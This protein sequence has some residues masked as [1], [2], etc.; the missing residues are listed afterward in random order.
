MNKLIH[1]SERMPAV[2]SFVQ[3]A[4]QGSFVAAARLQGISSAAVS[5]NIAGLE[6]AL[7]VRLMNRTTRSLMLTSEGAAFL[8]QVSVAMDALDLA[9]DTVGSQRTQLAGSVKM[10]TSN[11]F[12]MDYLMPLL[13]GLNQ[14]HPDLRL[15]IDFDDHRVDLVKGGYD[16]ALRGGTLEDSSLI[17]RK[18]CTLLTVLVASP[19]YLQASGVPK[20]VQDLDTHRHIALRFL[21]G[22]TS[23]WTLQTARGEVTEYAPIDPALRSLKPHSGRCGPGSSA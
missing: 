16:L 22:R 7:G 14:R 19:A 9:M 10:S 15:E 3:A 6:G 5:K 11:A 2:V 18:V 23:P 13:P 8:A 21:N 12:G 17:A 20:R 4:R 1:P